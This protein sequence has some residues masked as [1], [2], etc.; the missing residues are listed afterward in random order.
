VQ[1]LPVVVFFSCVITMLYHLGVMQCIISKIA[2]VMRLTLGTTAPESLCAAG[3]IFVGQVR[4]LESIIKNI[5]KIFIFR[6]FL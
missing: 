4:F 3:N 6:N 5:R 1:V 2:F